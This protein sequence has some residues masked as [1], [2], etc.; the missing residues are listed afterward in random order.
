MIFQLGS[1]LAAG[2]G[3]YLGAWAVDAWRAYSKN[4][5]DSE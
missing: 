1:A 4:R 5:K 2:V 3:A